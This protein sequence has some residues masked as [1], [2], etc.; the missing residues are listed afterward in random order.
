MTTPHPWIRRVEVWTTRE[1]IELRAGDRVLVLNQAEAAD[2][3]AM[4]AGAV[5]CAEQRP[6]CQN[7]ERTVRA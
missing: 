5:E 2:A 3:A 7:C 4:L 1:G 6:H